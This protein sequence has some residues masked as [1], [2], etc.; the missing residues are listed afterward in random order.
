MKKRLFLYL[1]LIV[2]VVIMS[3]CS[4]TS[5]QEPD[6]HTFKLTTIVQP[7]HVWAKTAEKFNE[8]LQA[9]SDGRMKVD[10]YPSSQLGQEKDMIQQMESGVVDFGFIT[11]AYMSTR[12]P[13]FDAWFLPFLFDSTEEVIQMRDSKTA[14]K[15]LDRLREQRII[16]MDYLFTGNHHFLMTEGKIDSPE[17]LQGVKMRTTGAAIINETLEQFGATATSIPINEIYTSLQTGVVGG[18][19]A[20]VD[21]IVTQRFQEVA[22]DYSMLS[23]FAFPAVVVAS[24]ETMNNLSPEDQKIVYEAMKAAVD[25]GV[26]EAITVDNRDLAILKKEGLTVHNIENKKEFRSAVQN[27]YEKYA[28]KDP[29]V[30]HFINE[31]QEQ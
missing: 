10:I 9:R 30:E 27:I 2:S 26:K 22:A 5:G 11:N 13:Y 3:A 23:A 31:V 15:M 29:L 12:A 17:D 14:Q 8:E 25:W 7:T 24:E 16:G 6:T 18:I 21:G 4:Q 28:E 1:N 20:S 19:H